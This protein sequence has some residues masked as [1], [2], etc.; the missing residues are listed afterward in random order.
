MAA[1][2]FRLSVLI[3]VGFF[4]AS[5]Q[6]EFEIDGLTPPPVTGPAVFSWEGAPGVCATAIVGGVYAAGT[7]LDS[8]NKVTIVVNVT[9][10]GSYSI[11]TDTNNGIRF[12]S[13]GVFTATGPQSIILYGSGTPSAAVAAIF[14]GGPNACS[15]TI[16]TG[17]PLPP[18]VYT[19]TGA[20]GACTT[21]TVEGTYAVGTALNSSNKVTIAVDVTTSGTWSATT[22]TD[23]GIQFSG[24][25]VFSGT[26]AQTIV[27]QGSGTPVAAVTSTLSPGATACSFN[28]T[29]TAALP[30]ATY[31]W[32]G[33]TGPCTNA[34]VSGTYTV[35][36][37]LDNS[38][39][40][41]IEVNVTVPGSW[42]ATTIL[43]NGIQF[44][45]SGIFTATGNQTVTLQGSGTPVAAMVV[46]F[47]AGVSACSFNVTSVAAP[48][49]GDFLRATIDGVLR[50]FSL[51]AFAEWNNDTLSLGGMVPGSV[52]E[53]F[54]IDI[55]GSASLVTG[56]YE[57]EDP[58]SGAPVYVEAGYTTDA[59]DIW[60]VDVNA[61]TPRTDP[62]TVVITNITP[63]RVEG[64][65]F[66]GLWNST[67]GTTQLQVRN[68]EFSLPIQ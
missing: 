14:S 55:I 30:P 51:S 44:S 9:T 50:E 42:S 48:P 62:F 54:A 3:L 8:S 47:A 46:P 17:A 19:W 31:T 21:A 32:N 61:P 1:K 4:F 67:G 12:S 66:G 7:T 63:T 6:K 65:F 36:T 64:T 45:G 57:E 58:T 13:S 53:V 56:V 10:A 24:S 37:A 43:S 20:P 16:N 68:G 38:N 26:G 59:L 52:F 23:N 18:A 49:T 60:Y 22:N 34:N 27:L 15:F 40:V 2:L 41:T 33:G 39:F 29:A 28:V 11:T 25:G 35:G 5:C